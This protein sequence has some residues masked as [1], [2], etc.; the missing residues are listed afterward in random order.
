MFDCVV[1]ESL[2]TRREF[3]ASAFAANGMVRSAL[4]SAFPLFTTQMFINASF[5]GPSLLRTD[6][7][8]HVDG[9]TMGLIRH[10]HR[11]GTPCTHPISLFKVWST[12][13]RTQSVCTLQCECLPPPFPA[14]WRLPPVLAQ[15]YSLLDRISR[16]PKSSPRLRKRSARKN[17]FR[18]TPTTFK[19][20][21]IHITITITTHFSTRL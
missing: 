10:R 21:G 15:M 7:P 14:P 6:A 18:T 2:C 5:D 11:C 8:T 3:S 16:L 9:R 4:A 1:A 13:S 20:T 19:G 12:Y 17:P